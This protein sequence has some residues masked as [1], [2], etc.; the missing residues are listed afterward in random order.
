MTD[1]RLTG[2]IGDLRAGPSLIQCTHCGVGAEASFKWAELA[3]EEAKL[4]TSGRG[5]G[6]QP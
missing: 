6:R 5:K 3:V 4:S 2:V 1:A